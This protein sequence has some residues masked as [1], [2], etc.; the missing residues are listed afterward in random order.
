M[1]RSVKPGPV[2]IVGAVA[3]LVLTTLWWL[4]AG[5]QPSGR[6]TLVV[7]CAHDAVYSEEILQQFQQRTGI[8][9]ETRF[10]TEATK[11]LGL[12]ELIKQERGHPRCD[13]FWNNELLGTVDLKEQGLLEPYRGLGWTRIPERFR[14]PDGYWVGFGARLRVWIVNKNA[15]SA[16]DESLQ[17]AM[18]LETSRGAVAMPLFGTTLTHYTVLQHAWGEER[19]RR[20]HEEVRRRGLREV[21][22]NAMVKDV[23]ATGQADFG[24]TDTDDAFVALDDGAPVDMLPIRVEGKTIAIPNTVAIVRGCRHRGEAEQLVDFLASADTELKLAK[25]RA[26][27]IPLGPVEESQLPAEVQRL[28]GWADDGRDLRDLLTVRQ[29]VIAWLT[30]EYAP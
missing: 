30:A 9:V 5:P 29:A 3:A 20:W 10:D 8:R 26:R 24:W 2:V 23:V 14:D 15:L 12:V 19:L 11:S 18:E 25:S 22:G 4:T 27:Q 13:V 16:D 6:S 1:Q 21:K 28:K 17:T 7:Y